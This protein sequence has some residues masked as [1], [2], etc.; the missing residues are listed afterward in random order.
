[1]K[2]EKLNGLIDKYHR[3]QCSS[4]EKAFLEAWKSKHKANEAHFNQISRII[5]ELR[6]VPVQLN[7]DTGAEW[8]KLR[9][10]LE[11][12]NAN[13]DT[14]ARI[15]SFARRSVLWRVAA[16]LVFALGIFWM[17]Q[18]QQNQAPAIAQEYV[19]PRGETRQITLPDGSHIEL[20]ADSRLAVFE[21]FNAQNRNLELEGE[22]FF[23][24]AKNPKL[25]FT[26]QTG[27]V[28]TQVTG[29]AFNLKSYREDDRIELTVVEGSVRFKGPDQEVSVPANVAAVFDKTSRKIEP[30]PFDPDVALGW[31]EGRLVI[32]N[33]PMREGLAMLE[34]RFNVQFTD[35]SGKTGFRLIV[36]KDDDLDSV[37]E[38]LAEVLGVKIRRTQDNI[39]LEPR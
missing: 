27:D 29:T 5:R 39:I 11:T 16:L 21:G 7:P 23:K 37:L 1:M 32:Q 12:Q 26:I 28:I 24:V 17:Y 35:H 34:R 38:S 31:R 4:E 33:V 15:V 20:N 19:V 14:G 2:E 13:P 10:R 9:S 22:A 36:R 18:N 30:T 25:P 6:H 8:E 3:G